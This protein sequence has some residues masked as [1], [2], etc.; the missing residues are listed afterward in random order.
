VKDVYMHVV[1]E[2]DDGLIVSGAKVVATTSSLTHYNFI[3]NNGALPIKTKPF[4]FVCMVPTGAKGVK[5]LCRPSYEMMSAVMGTP[6]DYP[7][8][9]AWTR[10]TR[11]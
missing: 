11:S 10:T 9:A 6:F 2:K 1:D 7:C 3:A 5:L 4:A 8:R